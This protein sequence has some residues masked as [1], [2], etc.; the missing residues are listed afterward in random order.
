VSTTSQFV[1]R[2]GLVGRHAKA[3]HAVP[4]ASAAHAAAVGGAKGQGFFDRMF[5]GL[6]P[7]AASNDDLE[8]LA[9]AMKDVNPGDPALD[10]AAVPAGFTYLGQFIDHD[11]TLD[12]TALSAKIEDPTMLRNF[13]TPGL[14]LDSLYGAGLGPHRFLFRRDGPKFLIGTA[15]ASTDALGA[16]IPA[17]P[18]DL[19]RTRLTAVHKPCT[20]DQPA[21]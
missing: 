15:S 18:N 7:F 3:E 12:L 8:A 11:I 2:H 4:V 14:D 9:G 10:N 21:T 16:P 19:E 5:P 13:R 1:S 17:L 20:N 6:K